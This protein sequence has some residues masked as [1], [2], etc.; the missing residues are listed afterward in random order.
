M[1]GACAGLPLVERRA[2]AD[3]HGRHRRAW[4]SA[5]G[6]AAL[7]LTLNVQLLLPILG[8]LYVTESLSVILQ[9][10][11]FRIFKRRIF[12]MAPDPP[13]LRAGRLARD[14]GDHPLLAARRHVHRARPRPLLRRLHRHR[15]AGLTEHL[16]LGL[17]V[18]G[19][20]VLR[21]LVA[22]GEGAVVVDD[23]PYRRRARAGGGAGRRARGAPRRRRISA[24]LVGRRRRRRPEP[25]RARPPPGVRGGRGRGRAGPLRVRPGRAMGRSAARGHHRHQRQDDG[26]RA[27][28][29]DARGVGSPRPSRSATPRCRWSP[30]STTP[31]STC[32]SWR[33]RRSGCCTPGGTHRRSAPGS[34][35]PR[36][37]STTTPP[38]R[39]TW[40]PR[41]GSG[42]ISGPIRSPIG[43][44]DDPVVA[45]HLAEAPARHVTFGLGRGADHRLEGDRLVLADGATLADGGGAP[46]GLPPRPR[47]RAG[48]RRR[49]PA[50]RRHRRPVPATRCSPS[51]GS[52]I[53]C[54]WWARLEGCAGTTTR[55]PPRPMPPG[56]RSAASTPSVLIAG[57][58]NKGLDLSELADG[59]RPRPRRRGHRRGG[60]R[61]GGRLRRAAAGAHGGLDGRRGARRP[62]RW[63]GPATSCSCPRPA[64][65]STGTAPTPSGATTSSAPSG[66]HLAEER[67]P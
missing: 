35:S 49:H 1:V 16:V 24:R 7:V 6:V 10:G 34:T 51:G 42:P 38:S 53:G 54:R 48:G 23:R 61:G 62:H 65:R 27:H 32:S 50:R 8:A 67:R 60:A 17:G 5:P 30:P 13:P 40:R 58:R 36:T 56:P 45:A 59:G 12:R 20:A 55:R 19:R 21:A 9:V 33:R 29:S 26:H 66:E 11:S 31:P 15:R 43:N 18:T 47:Q 46:P 52:P 25:G 63:P 41:P 39:P 4:P 3:L 44:A 57:G 37:T 2:R 22:H 64:P 28:P 14:H